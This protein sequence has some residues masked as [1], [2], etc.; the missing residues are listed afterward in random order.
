MSANNMMGLLPLFLI[1]IV[2]YF[3]VFRP[4]QTKQK[5]H[6]RMVSSLEKG[7][8]VVTSGGMHGLVTGLKEKTIY[9]KIADNV[10]IEVNRGSI[11]AVE[12]AGN[13]DKK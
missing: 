12:K 4:Q 13:A 9:L 11:S 8:K 5:E 3:M 10:R 6:Q 1:F 2:F 7:D